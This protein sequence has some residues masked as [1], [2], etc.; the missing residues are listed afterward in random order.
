MC[1]SEFS[2]PKT[3][4]YILIDREEN[5]HC[6]NHIAVIGDATNRYLLQQSGIEQAKGLIITTNDDSI[7]IFLTLSSRNSNPHMRIVARANTEE[8]VAQLYAAGADFVVSNA[9]VGASILM[10]IL[11]SKESIFFDRRG[12]HLPPGSASGSGRQNN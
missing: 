8:N 9:S 12:Y 3:G 4:P 11:E 2:R 10:N 6:E 1:G 7:N 5:I